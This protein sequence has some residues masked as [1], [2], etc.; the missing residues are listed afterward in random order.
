MICVISLHLNLLPISDLPCWIVQPT[1][2]QAKVAG[3]SRPD[4]G[5]G[6]PE[7]PD[8]GNKAG[9]IMMSAWFRPEKYLLRSPPSRI[10]GW[11]IP[12]AWLHESTAA[13]NFRT[14]VLEGLLNHWQNTQDM[15]LL[16]IRDMLL[17]HIHNALQVRGWL[18]ARRR[19]SAEEL[20]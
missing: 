9:S 12:P 1:H 11:P 16:E 6:V 5:Q 17:V 2:E 20:T 15:T 14:N 4:L 18:V 3:R 13:E 10:C 8:A 7:E 19:V